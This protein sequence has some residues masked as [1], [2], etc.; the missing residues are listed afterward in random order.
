[1]IIYSHHFFILLKECVLAKAA[2]KQLIPSECQRLSSLIFLATKKRVSETTI[3]RVYGFAVSK[4]KPSP[5]TLQTLAEYCGYEGWEDFCERQELVTIKPSEK[6]SWRNLNTR[7]SRITQFTLQSLKKRSGIPFDLTIKRQFMNEHLEDFLKSGKQVTIFTAQSG[8]GK[9]IGLCHLVDSILEENSNL[10]SD[11]NLVLFFSTLAI[12]SIAANDLNLDSWFLS[13]LGLQANESLIERFEERETS[14]GNFYFIIDGFDE[15]AFKPDRF[16]VFFNQLIDIISYYSK[17]PWF[18]VI[19]NMRSSTW[20]NYRYLII[21]KPVLLENWHLGFML[22]ENQTVNVLPFD[23]NEILALSKKLNPQ[24]KTNSLP[25]VD[26]IKKLNFPLF[27]Q[28]YYQ[29]NPHH[30]T[31]AETDHLYFYDMISAYVNSKIHYGT[32]SMEKVLL[33]KGLLEMMDF[34]NNFFSVEKI[35]FSTYIKNYPNTYKELVNIDIFCEE[36]FSKNLQ[37]GEFISFSNSTVLEY[38]V[39]RMLYSGNHEKLDANLID[40][41]ENTLEKSSIKTD[42]VKWIIFFIVNNNNYEQLNYL[43]DINLYPAGKLDV[44][45]F[46]CELLE[47]KLSETQDQEKL[48]NY[49]HEIE[50]SETFSFFLSLQYVTPEY[51]KALHTLLAFDLTNRNKIQI[52]S[53]LALMSILNMNASKAEKH[54][55]TLAQFPEADLQDFIVNPLLCLNTIFCYFQYGIV[56]KDALQAITHLYFQDNKLRKMDLADYNSNEIILKLILLTLIVNNNPAKELRFINT[57]MKFFKS[58]FLKENSALNIFYIGVSAN[59][60]LKMGN[61]RKAIK[62]YNELL[63]IQNSDNSVY[64]PFMKILFNLLSVRNTT[65]N[66]AEQVALMQVKSLIAYCNKKGFKLA[67]VYTGISYLNSDQIKNTDV[68]ELIEIYN[69]TLRQIRSSGFRL[70]SFVT[71]SLQTKVENLT[72]KRS[73]VV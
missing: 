54:I 47:K 64:T 28:L 16:S 66:Q 9:T 3:K 12:S 72:G 15:N 43:K 29:S 52:Y 55:Q 21:G 71:A 25:S 30:F 46:T 4:F 67:E 69:N 45:V 31:I 17:F 5:F 35:R 14:T 27:F 2:I 10:Q 65:Q 51:E 49:F 42:V 62:M 6:I 50:K 1:M 11:K 58:N 68:T 70:E 40:E 18:K 53:T 63:R 34:K 23:T 19:L 60:Y 61:T 57:V 24:I 59:A 36:N 73:M 37:Y 26:L 56:L 13:F 8:Y 41:I 38:S 48:K 20:L 22:N 44:I 33:F 39:A 32:N 7:A